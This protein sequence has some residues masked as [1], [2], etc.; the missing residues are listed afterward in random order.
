MTQFPAMKLSFD[1]LSAD[2]QS[3]SSSGYL[4]RVNMSR[5]L[6]S[7]KPPSDSVTEM[8]SYPDSNK[9]WRSRLLNLGEDV[10]TCTNIPCS[11]NIMHKCA[12]TCFLF[13]SIFDLEI[14][15]PLDFGFGF[16][17]K[18]GV[19]AEKLYVALLLSGRVYVH[20]PS[21]FAVPRKSTCTMHCLD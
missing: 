3:L 15:G 12:R 7:L 17:L 16:W 6:H 4:I 20:R 18:Q 2:R 1:A 19:H 21:V 5:E 9:K 10:S 11:R 8:S 14:Y 13:T